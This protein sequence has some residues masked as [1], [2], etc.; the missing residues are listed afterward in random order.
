MVTSKSKSAASEAPVVEKPETP[1]ETKPETT[2][3]DTPA[4][5]EEPKEE[6]K[7]EVR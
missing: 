3:A 7:S 6:K 2:D 5:S 1:T 4:V